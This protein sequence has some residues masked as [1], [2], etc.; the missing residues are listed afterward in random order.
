M[1]KFLNTVK[2]EING[3][4]E[5]FE[6]EAWEK[7]KRMIFPMDLEEGRDNWHESD[8]T[9]LFSECILVDGLWIDYDLIPAIEYGEYVEI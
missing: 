4:I 8:L 5:N 1:C 3:H 9:R 6:A 2:V 7:V